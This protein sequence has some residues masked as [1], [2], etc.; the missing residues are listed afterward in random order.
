M[1]RIA[2]AVFVVIIAFGF[3]AE[4]I[5]AE[6]TTIMVTKRDCQRIIAH[7]PRGDVEYK[8]GVDVRGKKVKGA[9]L[10]G[11]NPIK[12]PDEITIDVGI[13]LA[14]KYGLGAGGQYKAEGSV[15]KVTVKGNKTYWNG[16]PLDQAEQNAI[17][18]ACQ[19][20]FGKR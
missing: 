15:G 16:Q 20:K 13:N 14:D 12:M 11:G 19:E 2:A 4:A 6:G 10:P 9:D 3:T 18:R 7:Q 5:A 17:A 8:P 1:H